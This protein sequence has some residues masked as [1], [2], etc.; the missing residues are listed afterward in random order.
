MIAALWILGAL[1]LLLLAGIA[2][3][4]RA[5]REATDEGLGTGLLVLALEGLALLVVVA[6]MTDLL[7]FLC[8]H[9]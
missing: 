4:A 3:V 5:G 9:P 6:W 2:A 7:L 8:V 1:F